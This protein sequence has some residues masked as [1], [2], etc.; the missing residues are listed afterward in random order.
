MCGSLALHPVIIY[1]SIPKEE[2][3]FLGI[4]NL[5][6]IQGLPESYQFFGVPYCDGTGIGNAVPPAM[7]AGCISS[8]T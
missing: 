2:G 1:D 7:A 8:F 5:A 6:R 3:L 4:R